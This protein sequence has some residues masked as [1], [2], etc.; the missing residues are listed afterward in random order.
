MAKSGR[1][2]SDTH[3]RTKRHNP[4]A[5]SA[6]PSAKSKTRAHKLKGMRTQLAAS[7][8]APSE[9]TAPQTSQSRKEERKRKSPR[10]A[11]V[12]KSQ[13]RR[14]RSS[15]NETVI[16][17]P[18]PSLAEIPR[19]LGRDLDPKLRTP[20]RGVPDLSAGDMDA[21]WDR[22][23]EGEETVGGSQPTPDQDVVEDIG[24]AVGVTY[25][26]NEPLRLGEKEEE[27]DSQRSELDP[28]SSEDYKERIDR[29]KGHQ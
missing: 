13:A 15:R 25:S 5:K 18:L 29:E 14:K 11:Q 3:I 22:A 27:R 7:E 12:P 28:A 19:E 21:A 24:K 23:D 8:S 16:L 4:V 17:P 2:K 26:G 6:Q 10:K 1:A 20:Q 9:I